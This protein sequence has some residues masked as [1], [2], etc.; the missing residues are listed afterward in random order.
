MF[1]RGLSRCGMLN[2]L[3]ASAVTRN[4]C[5][6]MRR[7]FCTLTSALKYL[8]FAANASMGSRPNHVR[9]ALASAVV[10][11]RP[12]DRAVHP[13]ANDAVPVEIPA[14]RRNAE[15]RLGP[16]LDDA[17]H[18]D[19]E[20]QIDLHVTLDPVTAIVDTGTDIEIRPLGEL[21]VA[22]EIERVVHR[23]RE[24]VRHAA[25]EAAA[26]PLF[27]IHEQPFVGDR[28]EV[29]VEALVRGGRVGP[30]RIGP[31]E[32][33]RSRDAGI[34]V[35][36]EHVIVP[37]VIHEAHIDAEMPPEFAPVADLRVP[38]VAGLQI[39]VEN[40][41]AGGRN[42]DGAAAEGI[43]PGGIVDLHADDVGRR[44]A[45]VPDDV[46]NHLVVVQAHAA[47]KGLRRPRAR[48]PGEADTGREIVLVAADAGTGAAR[49]GLQ[50]L[51]L[52][53]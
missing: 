24:R 36:D 34:G 47:I 33:R 44:E 28:T 53:A 45:R 23:L 50:R 25:L 30:D 38:V 37:A 19:P 17:P 42:P 6:P 31:C 15:R 2:T 13:I 10:S 7:R 43:G 14:A 4:D 5:P 12:A 20:W 32:A 9:R 21:H 41:N 52:R 35:D 1:P 26:E 16:E 39:G 29:R 11:S 22:E 3:N 8:G 40:R 18:P 51:R 27:H 48:C 46:Q 49:G